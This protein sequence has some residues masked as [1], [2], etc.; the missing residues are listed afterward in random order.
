MHERF[1]LMNGRFMC[2]ALHTSGHSIMLET[3]QAYQKPYIGQFSHLVGYSQYYITATIICIDYLMTKLFFCPSDKLLLTFF[4]DVC[5]CKAG[6][7]LAQH[8]SF[9]ALLANDS[10]WWTRFG[11]L[12]TS[13]CALCGT[14][15]FT[16][17]ASFQL[18]MR[19]FH[20]HVIT[21]YNTHLCS[22]NAVQ[23]T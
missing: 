17:R 1:L 10:F 14:D 6:L 21:L 7:T 2:C 13:R 8:S 11:D 22:A 16:N 12:V 3:Q 15:S 9:D 20:L 18:H 23:T 5:I 19:R 4:S